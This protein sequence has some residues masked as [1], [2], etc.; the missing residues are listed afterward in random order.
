MI[1]QFEVATILYTVK[2]RLINLR[3]FKWMRLLVFKCIIHRSRKCLKPKKKFSE[4]PQHLDQWYT[5]RIG[6]I[7]LGIHS[8]QT[9]NPGLG[10]T[11]LHKYLNLKLQGSIH[12]CK[13]WATVCYT[14]SMFL[15]FGFDDLKSV[16]K[17]LIV[18]LDT[19]LG[20]V[21]Q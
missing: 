11:K 5:N 2:Q 15:S 16:S 4:H 19:W 13:D 9:S 1:T 21:S 17:K 7:Q 8:D 18:M 20:S 14:L 3:W 6:K 10:S 12:L